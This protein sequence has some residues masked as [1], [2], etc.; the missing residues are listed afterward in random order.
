MSDA[1]L[2][3]DDLHVRFGEATGLRGI[4][5]TVGA[6]ER[7]VLLGPSGSGKTTL[8]RAV[9]GLA[10]IA[11]GRVH[12]RGVEVSAHPPERRDVAYLHQT[13]LLFPHLSV[14]ENVAFPLRIRR[15]PEP[16]LRR[17]AT[18][19]LDAVRLGELAERRPATLSGGQRHRVALARA[20]AARPAVLLLDEPFSALDPVLRDEVRAATLALQAGEGVALLAVTHDQGDAVFGDRVGVLLDGRLAQVA[21]AAE[22]FRRPASL[23]VARFLG[24]PNRVPGVVTGGCFVA[25]ALVILVDGPCAE[26]PAVALFGA[27]GLRPTSDGGIPGVV[28]GTRQHP[29]V[30]TLLVTV[31]D[32]ELETLAPP[33]PV[34][35]PGSMLR[36]AA[37]A[38]RIAVLPRGDDVR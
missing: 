27:E 10:P 38:S 22:V 35:P 11:A 14:F 23:E 13:P 6:G 28:R 24:V 4:T 31:D 36:L 37:D 3:L 12:V 7:V 29:F 30:T 16:A 9:A 8:L 26:G 2:A 1:A 20:M 5:L 33:G 32:R 15:V 18:A 34:P 25:G 21:P 19:L 17:R